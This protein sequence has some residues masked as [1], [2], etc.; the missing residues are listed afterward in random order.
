MR[1]RRTICLRQ[2]SFCLFCYLAVFVFSFAST[3]EV[4]CLE[5]LFLPN[6]LA[7]EIVSKMSNGTLNLTTN[8]EEVSVSFVRW[9]DF[10]G[11]PSIVLV[12]IFWS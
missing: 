9:D 12:V 8:A 5:D 1:S 11:F 3:S 6:D 4:I 7:E 2:L 10:P